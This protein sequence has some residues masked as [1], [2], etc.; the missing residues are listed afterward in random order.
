MRR[1]LI[2]ILAKLCVFFTEMKMRCTIVYGTINTAKLIYTGSGPEQW[3]GRKKE[4]SVNVI[5]ATKFL[6]WQGFQRSS[7]LRML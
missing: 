4:A 7:L 6:I 1:V 2:C 3:G 5:S